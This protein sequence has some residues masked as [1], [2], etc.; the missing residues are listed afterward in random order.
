MYV[1]QEDIDEIEKNNGIKCK[2]SGAGTYYRSG[3]LKLEKSNTQQ[4]G[5]EKAEKVNERTNDR[6]KEGR[7][8]GMNEWMDGWMNRQT[9]R[10]TDGRMDGRMGE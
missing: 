5:N 8:E 2:I 4:T 9:E 6:T 3:S 1:T 10:R 7:R